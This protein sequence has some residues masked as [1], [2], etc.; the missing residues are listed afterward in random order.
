MPTADA[1]AT[2]RSGL[3]I[4]R[5]T[6]ADMVA[7]ARA[8][9]GTLRVAPRG[10]T[11]LLLA[12]A[13]PASAAA[14]FEAWTTPHLLTQWLGSPEAPLSVPVQELRPGGAY[15][16]EIPVGDGAVMGWGGTYLEV[17]APQGFTATERFDSAW[18]PGEARV[19]LQLHE[20]AG[21]TVATLR[22][23]YESLSARDL[24]LRSPM[25]AGLAT[26]FERLEGLIAPR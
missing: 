4:D 6:L 22:L 17:K 21:A 5:P 12:R 1:P 15:R 16:F 7:E 2:L 24:V 11:E 13:F 10:D 25:D 9:P 3:P 18:Y 20:G 8:K 19:E 26:C 23:T 14:V